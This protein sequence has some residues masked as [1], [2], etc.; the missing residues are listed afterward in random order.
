MCAYGA[1]HKKPT[2]ILTNIQ[3]F[4]SLSRNCDKS[5]VHEPLV[6]TT[7]TQLAC[8]SFVQKNRTALAGQYPDVLCGRWASIL[9]NLAPAEAKLSGRSSH[10]VFTFG[11]ELSK[12]LIL[13]AQRKKTTP[14]WSRPEFPAVCFSDG[15]RLEAICELHRQDPTW[16][17]C[18]IFGQH[19]NA[20]VARRKEK[21]NP[22]TW[23]RVLGDFSAPSGR[24]RRRPSSAQ[25]PQGREDADADSEK[26]P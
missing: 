11:D 19:S 1:P 3:Q 26:V 22:I 8:G 24:Q 17:D 9:A 25:I 5:H 13:A 15:I 20:E 10:G 4:C 23:S 18:V 14:R 6:G 12:Q 2:A 21:K 16:Q 7:R